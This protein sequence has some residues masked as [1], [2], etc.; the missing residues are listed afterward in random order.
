MQTSAH[1]GHQ[2]ATPCDAVQ[3]LTPGHRYD[4]L[5]GAGLL[6]AAAAWQDLP[7]AVHAVVVS[8]PTVHGHYGQTL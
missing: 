1:E 6:G 2:A 8:N 5:I 4:I 7:R 3:V